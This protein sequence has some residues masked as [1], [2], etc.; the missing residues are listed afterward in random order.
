MRK[1]REEREGKRRRKG[2]KEKRGKKGRKKKRRRRKRRR[3]SLK[4]RFE[5]GDLTSHELQTSVVI[6]WLLS[7]SAHHKDEPEAV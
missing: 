4:G 3:K 5:P 2:R 6:Q 7:S 1:E